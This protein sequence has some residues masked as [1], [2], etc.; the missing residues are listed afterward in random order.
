M[1]VHKVGIRE[2]RENL[3]T[4][5]NA[6]SPVTVTRHGEVLGVFVPQPRPTEADIEELRE[7]G[8]KMQESMEAAG[9]DEEALVAE[10][11]RLR[12]EARRKRREKIAAT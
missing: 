7:A 1:Q 12:A 5:L 6:D 2:F 11:E 9:L 3:S 8:Q 10:F 4:Y